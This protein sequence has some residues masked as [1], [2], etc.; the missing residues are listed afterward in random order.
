MIKRALRYAILAV[1]LLVI[2]ISLIALGISKLQAEET[3]AIEVTTEER[4]L[5]ARMVFFESSICSDECQQAI[6]SVAINQW[7]AGYWGDDL[8][9]ILKNRN[10]YSTADRILYDK[11]E[12]TSREYANVDFVLKN[13]CT[14]DSSI[15]YFR[16]NHHFTWD[17]Y[18]GV[19][20]IDNVYFGHFTN[21]N[22]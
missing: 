1:L 2:S 9:E 11:L 8:S 19:L 18:E 17:G 16:N 6:V 20:V 10:I 4:E 7:Q 15:R 5:L 14:I 3:N 13:G 12:P 22:H 21:G